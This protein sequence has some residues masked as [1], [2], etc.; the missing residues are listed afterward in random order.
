MAD[1]KLNTLS[2][3]NHNNHVFRAENGKSGGS[4]SC[5]GRRGKDVV[6]QVP[7][8]TKI[9]C[10]K[11][12]KLLGDMIQY[13]NIPL[14]VA[15]GGRRGLGIRNNR[16]KKNI[17]HKKNKDVIQ[18]RIQGEVGE[19]KNLLLELN[20]IADVGIVGLPNSGKSSFVRI[21]SKATP[22]VADYPFTTLVPQL[23][24]V[25]VDGYADNNRFIIAD[26]PGIIKGASSGCGLGLRF[27]KHLTRCRML[28]H[29]V[30]INSVDDSDP[31]KNII[32]IEQ[33]LSNYD[34]QLI[35]KPRWLVFNKIDLLTQS[36]L[37]KKIDVIVKSVQWSGRYYAISIKHNVNIS[38]LCYDIMNCIVHH[39]EVYR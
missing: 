35:N 38:E 3:F 14:M 33:E 17:I 37:F 13:R 11:T 26:I 20:L 2:H 12:H 19:C 39:A 16:V 31:V 25:K 34:A 9:F 27:L 36:E 7:L 10:S 23:G 30:D 22:K 18:N 15:R 1:P 28:L 29:F 24:S 32:D 21:I 8:G 6:I 4:G 5:T